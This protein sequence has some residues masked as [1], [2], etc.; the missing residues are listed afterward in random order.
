EPQPHLRRLVVLAEGGRHASIADD[1]VLGAG[2]QWIWVR[3]SGEDLTALGR[4]ADG[5]RLTVD[6]AA[7]FP[8]SEL[9]A[10][11]DLSREG[12]TP[13]KIVVEV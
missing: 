1:A 8:L 12:H 6:V 5:D 2:G 3:P 11:F 9:G 13:G 10:A 7:T 4:L